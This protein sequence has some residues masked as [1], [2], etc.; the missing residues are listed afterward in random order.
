MLFVLIVGAGPAGLT[1]A[2][3][4]ARR[5]VPH[6]IVDREPGPVLGSRGKALQPRTLEVLDDLGLVDEVLAHSGTALPYRTYIGN[7]PQHDGPAPELTDPTAAT[8]FTNT[9]ILPQWRLEEILR[10]R[11]AELGS[12]VDSRT[13]LAGFHDDG[14]GVLATVQKPDASTEV[15]RVRYLVGADGAKSLVRKQLGVDF[16]G[17]D[18]N[19]PATLV[20]DVKVTGLDR[21]R[22]HI[23]PTAE[24]GPLALIPLPSTD[25]FQF[26]TIAGSVSPDLS[27]AG[28]RTEFL[29]RTSCTAVELCEIGSLSVYRPSVRMAD[30]FRV[31]PVFLCGDACHIHPPAGAQGMNTGIQDA[32]NLGWKLAHVF[33]G[34]PVSLLDTYEAERMPVVART[35]GMV[36]ELYQEALAGRIGAQRDITHTHQLGITYRSGPLA[37]GGHPAAAVRAGD[38]MPDAQGRDQ[39]GSPVRLFDLTRGPHWTLLAFGGV[40]ET[41]LDTVSGR[42]GDLVHVH[43]AV[44]HGEQPRPDAFADAEDQLHRQFGAQD[45]FVVLIR[46]DGYVGYLGVDPSLDGVSNYLSGVLPRGSGG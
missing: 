20:G 9:V 43:R 15:M 12:Q 6:R 35:L 13:T 2:C 31:G 24:G 18:Q 3:E 10:N 8:P 14:D 40:A 36:K 42:H 26:S 1:L 7:Q 45:G 17:E 5:G 25:F 46:P 11:L 22:S 34:A 37:A 33:D 29:R 28:L 38:R 30:R 16:R 44:R 41:E 19:A 39:A 32:C 21:E 27:L 4:L 23:W